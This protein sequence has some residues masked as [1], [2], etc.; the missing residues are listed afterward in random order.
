M[1]PVPGSIITYAALITACGN[2]GEWQHAQALLEELH[3]FQ[4]E[5]TLSQA[6]NLAAV[7]YGRHHL[8]GG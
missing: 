6:A 2:C 5:L 8:Q 7:Q 1:V 4:M 3:S